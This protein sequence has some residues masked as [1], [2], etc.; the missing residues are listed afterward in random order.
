MRKV[1]VKGVDFG[2]GLPKIAIP[3]MGEGMPALYAEL[4]YAKDLPADLLE[5]RA[6]YYFGNT[7]EAPS[8][9]REKAGEKP[10]LCTV[11][12]RKE[13]GQAA[14]TPEEYEAVVAAL[15]G[16]GRFDLVDLELSCGHERLLRLVRLAHEREMAVV[17]SKHD[18]EKTPPEHEIFCTLLEMERLGA[19]LPKYAVMPQ[20]ARDVLAL[21][22]ATE[23]A[24]REFGPVVTMSMGPLGKISRASGAYFGSCITFAA[25]KNTSAPGQISAEDLKAV[26]QDLDPAH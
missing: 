15:I 1:T 25:G 2:E 16:T 10:L 6:D 14:L 17:I 21:L 4:E 3:L 26:L 5:W 20:N 22:S 23:R 12:T 19:E 8:L 9:L 24:S 11:R 13:G 7:L 18:F